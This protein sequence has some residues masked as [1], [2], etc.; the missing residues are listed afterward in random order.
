VPPR[1][2]PQSPPAAA[3]SRAP[4]DASPAPD[5]QWQHHIRLRSPKAGCLASAEGDL[6]SEFLSN[7]SGPL[8]QLGMPLTPGIVAA[9]IGMGD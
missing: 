6:V 1:G 2:A 8:H 5:G 7:S 4:H 3:P 9:K